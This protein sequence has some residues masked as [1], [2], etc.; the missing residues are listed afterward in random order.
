MRRRRLRAVD[1]GGLVAIY[2]AL[3]FLMVIVLIS[4]GMFLYTARSVSE[5]GEFSD[6]LY[7]RLTEDQVTMVEALSLNSTYGMPVIPWSNGTSSTEEPLNVTLGRPEAPTIGWLLESWCELEWRSDPENHEYDG[8][9]D[10][11]AILPIVDAYF[12][13]DRLPGTNHAWALTYNGSVVLF[14]SSNASSI[15]EL[16]GD[17]WAASRDYSWS[18]WVD[19]KE[20]VYYTA[21]LRYFLWLE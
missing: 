6:D 14:G 11:S 13:E 5:G 2:D 8:T 9:W 20:T 16:P 12:E 1:D 15:D 19:G 3:L 7:Q 18:L 17:R 10:T 21:E 4:V